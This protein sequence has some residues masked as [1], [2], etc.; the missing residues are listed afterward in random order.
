MLHSKET[1]ER[2]KNKIEWLFRSETNTL[3]RRERKKRGE[4]FN[5]ARERWK[6]EGKKQVYTGKRV[7][8]KCGVVVY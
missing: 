8:F 7:M 2:K 6:K 3:V 5:A 4:K 1:I